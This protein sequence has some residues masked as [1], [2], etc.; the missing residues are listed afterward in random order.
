MKNWL[1]KILVKIEKRFLRHLYI[2]QNNAALIQSYALLAMTN[3]QP[4]VNTPTRQQAITVSLT[5]YGKRIHTVYLAIESILVQSLKADRIILWLAEDEFS[6]ET[7]PQ[8]L[9][10]QQARGLSIRFCKDIRSYKKLIPTLSLYPNDLIMTI[11]DDIIYPV[12]HLDR[13]YQAYQAE[14]N[15]IHCHRAHKM[16][17]NTKGQLLPYAKWHNDDKSRE[18]SMNS[19]PTS[20]AGTLYFPGCFHHDIHREDL[21]TELCPLADDIWFKFMSYRAGIQCKVIAHS[22]KWEEYITIPESSELT[23]WQVNQFKNDEQIAAVLAF[24]KEIELSP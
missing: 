20:G 15:V 1:K 5:T 8:T 11:D 2:H 6:L 13:L 10:K 22:K 12:D 7:L 9:K 19:F 3:E 17:F 23:L 16:R 14:P 24:F 21:F 4:G 18:A